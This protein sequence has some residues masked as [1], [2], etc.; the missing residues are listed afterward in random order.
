VWISIISSGNLLPIFLKYLIHY[1]IRRTVN[2]ST[3]LFYFSIFLEESYSIPSIIDKNKVYKIAAILC[4]LTGIVL[5]NVY[6]SHVISGLN[7]PL[8]GQKLKTI[9]DFY[10]N[11]SNETDNEL[12]R[13]YDSRFWFDVNDNSSKYFGSMLKPG[14]EII[15]RRSRVVFTFLSEPAKLPYPKKC[16]ASRQKPIYI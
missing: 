6:V 15:Y 11:M 1:N 4:L 7:A 8:Q 16:V 5:T 12:I 14:L 10:V 3:W 9:S 13:F 2:F